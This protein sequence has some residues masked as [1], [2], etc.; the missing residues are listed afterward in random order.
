MK[1]L[2]LWLVCNET[3]LSMRTKLESPFPTVRNSCLS[4]QKGLSQGGRATLKSHI[5]SNSTRTWYT[6]RQPRQKQLLDEAF[7]GNSEEYVIRRLERL[8]KRCT[9]TPANCIDARSS[10]FTL[11]V[12]A[13]EV[14]RAMTSLPT[15]TSETGRLRLKII[16]HAS[17]ADESIDPC[18]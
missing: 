5:S 17:K 13:A 3:H 16:R 9:R 8:L 10:S 4:S 2:C 12:L 14:W 18:G 6:R 1:F 7:Q 15:D 11:A